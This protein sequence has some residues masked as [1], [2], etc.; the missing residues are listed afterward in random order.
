MTV[1]AV[2]YSGLSIMDALTSSATTTD[3]SFAIDS[4]STVSVTSADT[5]SV[6]LSQLYLRQ[7]WANTTCGN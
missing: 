6:S 7:S 2:T 3:M 5:G 4:S 1:T